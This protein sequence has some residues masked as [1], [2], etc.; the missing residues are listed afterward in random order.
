MWLGD[1]RVFNGDFTVGLVALFRCLAGDDTGHAF[2]GWWGTVSWVRS[3]A[4]F[5]R[6][7]WS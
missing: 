3:T 5:L 6:E 2:F 1:D 4:I 7:Q